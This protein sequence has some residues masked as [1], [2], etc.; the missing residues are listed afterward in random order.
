M[1]S[2]RLRPYHLPATLLPVAIAIG[3]AGRSPLAFANEK[4]TAAA[5]VDA[6]EQAGPLR[7]AGKLREARASLRLCSAESCPVAV[8]KD[9]IAAAAQADADVPTITFSVQGPR[10][11]DLT[12]VVVTLDGQPLVDRLDGKAVDVDPGEHLFRFETAG[13]PPVEKR[14]VV[15]QG[16]KN[17][18]EKVQLGELA[19]VAPVV[20]LSPVQREPPPDRQRTRGLVVGGVGLGL[21]AVGGASGLVAALEWSAAKSACGAQF[22]VSCA[23]AATASSDRSATVAASTVADVALGVGGA[24]LITG[25]VM[26]LLAPP[27]GAVRSG[28][29]TAVPQLGP[30]AGGILLQGRF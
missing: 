12:A 28:S 21:L 14:I 29:L 5:C 1:T 7:H 23:Q 22:P 27:P 30:N 16:Q 4:V 10:G 18:Q 24:A 6:N 26:V 3:L 13:L 15:I 17:R 19:P 8:R 2:A 9:C 25:A 11:D 20:L